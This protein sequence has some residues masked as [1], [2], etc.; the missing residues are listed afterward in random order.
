MTLVEFEA[1]ASENLS[2]NNEESRAEFLRLLSTG[3]LVNV[4]DS[5]LGNERELNE[6]ANRSYYH[7][8]GFLKIVLI[9]KRPKY[10]VRFHIWPE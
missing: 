3:L 1:L 5:L 4:I 8:N 10:S 7:S 6:V 2:I 9:E